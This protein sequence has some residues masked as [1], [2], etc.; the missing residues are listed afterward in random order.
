MPIAIAILVTTAKAGGFLLG[1]I[2]HE[3]SKHF[4]VENETTRASS[5]LI[6]KGDE[7]LELQETLKV[8]S[9]NV[10]VLSSRSIVKSSSSSVL[11]ILSNDSLESRFN[12]LDNN[13]LVS[14]MT[15]LKLFAYWYQA[16]IIAMVQSAICSLFF[17]MKVT[18]FSFSGSVTESVVE[19]EANTSIS[20]IQ[21]NIC[22]FLVKIIFTL[23]EIVRLIISCAKQ[24]VSRLVGRLFPV[25][26]AKQPCVDLI[27]ESA[28]VGDSNLVE[29]GT[30]TSMMQFLTMPIT[31]AKQALT[32]PSELRHPFLIRGC[33]AFAL[34]RLSLMLCVGI[35]LIEWNIPFM[36]AGGKHKEIVLQQ[37]SSNYEHTFGPV[38]HRLTPLPSVLSNSLI[39]TEHTTNLE[40][41]Y[42]VWTALEANERHAAF[43]PDLDI[44][45][46]CFT[47]WPDNVVSTAFISQ[48][49]HHWNDDTAVVSPIVD[50]NA[51]PTHRLHSEAALENSLFIIVLQQVLA[52]D[53][54][55]DGFAAK[56]F[57]ITV[58]K[59]FDSFVVSAVVDQIFP[60]SF[61]AQLP[62]DKFTLA[63]PGHFPLRSVSNR[64]TL[65]KLIV[66]TEV[67]PP[68][69]LSMIQYPT[70]DGSADYSCASH[71]RLPLVSD[72]ISAFAEVTSIQYS[73]KDL[74]QY[75]LSLDLSSIDRR[76]S[77]PNSIWDLHQF[78][79]LLMVLLC[80]NA[81]CDGNT[82]GPDASPASEISPGADS[83][84]ASEAEA[85]VVADENGEEEALLPIANFKSV[86]R[87]AT[88]LQSDLGRHWKSPS[89]R[90]KR[91]SSRTRSKP[92]YYEPE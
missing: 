69:E 18:I 38:T 13:H 77:V 70:R 10:L 64:D 50:W 79:L 88:M 75:G 67:D 12:I 27:H 83:E 16:R 43:Y 42:S 46:P 90:R 11:A 76:I 59:A 44:D 4:R 40:D 52:E 53:H 5:L 51:G 49:N 30:D 71:L 35:S 66:F 6:A 73:P 1:S 92:K 91:K 33:K 31:I 87:E 20:S 36:L 45:S 21:M 58:V 7:H 81:D 80:C 68:Q 89:K 54:S 26:P 32:M 8:V 48:T 37:S 86:R 39:W 60:P 41:L 23:K 24:N 84:E 22:A 15:D 55:S 62:K 2:V 9:S 19:R 72:R 63:L 14:F 56:Q 34:L 61:I 85:A 3:V 82:N 28:S 65:S 57:A 78:V 25:I 47:F 74:D 17:D 29:V